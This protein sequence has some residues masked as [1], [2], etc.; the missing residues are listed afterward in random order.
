[1]QSLANVNKS[2][3]NRRSYTRMDTHEKILLGFFL[4]CGNSITS[5]AVPLD[6][7]KEICCKLLLFE[8]KSINSRFSNTVTSK[9]EWFEYYGGFTGDTDRRKIHLRITVEGH[10]VLEERLLA[11]FLREVY[12]AWSDKSGNVH[13][14][15]NITSRLKEIENFK[16]DSIRMF[17]EKEQKII[18]DAAFKFSKS[19]FEDVGN[20]FDS[21]ED[22]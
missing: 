6:R 9:P 3:D 20:K 7:A 18:I 5:E 10:R 1:M 16:L 17:V 8:P 11:H 13:E 22:E 2:V 12:R 14:I 15:D 19:L 21:L 4:A